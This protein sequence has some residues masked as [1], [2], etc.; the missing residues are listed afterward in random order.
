MSPRSRRQLLHAGAILATGLAGCL[1][2]SSPQSMADETTRAP[3]TEPT[4]TNQTAASTTAQTST[5]TYDSS[6]ISSSASVVSQQTTDHPP[7]IKL[8]IKN[9][10][11]E[12][13]PVQSTDG[14]G[15]PLEFFPTVE[16]PESNLVLYPTEPTHWQFFGGDELTDKQ[17]DGCWRFA[18]DDGAEPRYG[19][20]QMGETVTLSPGG[21]FSIRHEVYNEAGGGP[22][23]PTGKYQSVHSLTLAEANENGPTVEFEYTV[24]IK[25]S[26]EIAVSV[27]KQ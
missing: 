25:D 2:D 13:V 1:S 15:Y 9:D 19:A 18:T 24:N 16:G 8:T 10:G 14:G 23:Y 22:C 6:Q 20:Q 4:S 7:V 26:G 12:A 11:D 21:T 3:T 17:T 5:P 27:E